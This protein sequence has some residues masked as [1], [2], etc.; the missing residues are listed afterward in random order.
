MK[1]NIEIK[2][3]ENLLKQISK[4][5]YGDEYFIEKAILSY[6][7]QQ[8]KTYTFFRDDSKEDLLIKYNWCQRPHE[9]NMSLHRFLTNGEIEAH[10]SESLA[11]DFG[12]IQVDLN[13]F[14]FRF[15]QPMIKDNVSLK[16]EL[17]KYKRLAEANLKDAEDYKQNMCEHR[18]LVKSHYEE[19]I[20]T[21]KKIAE[22]YERECRM[23]KAFCRK[24][25]KDEKRNVDEFNQGR[26]YAYIQFLNLISG[27]Q[28]WEHEGK[29][30]DEVDK[31]LLDWAR[32]EVE[33]DV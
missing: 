17:E 31:E 29:Y 5:K 15:V 32:K 3:K 26:E 1:D 13:E 25:R 16:S 11:E 8:E 14:I 28:N 21:Y 9:D 23:F 19:K 10:M 7:A 18:C 4:E 2:N 22:R 24:I 30:F 6:K 27:E 33:K 12:L 20:E